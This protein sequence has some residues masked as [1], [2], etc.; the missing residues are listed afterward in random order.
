[1]NI[2]VS[3]KNISAIFLIIILVTGT[4]NLFLP[5]SFIVGAAQASSDREKDREIWEKNKVSKT[6]HKPLNPINTY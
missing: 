5:S 3:T 2:I 1:L 6:I 4:I